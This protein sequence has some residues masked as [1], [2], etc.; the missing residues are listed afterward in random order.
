[1]SVYTPL[2]LEE[3]Q[4]FAE[5]YGLAVIDLIPI[6]GGIQNTNYFLVD[7][8]QKQ[9]V[10]TVFEELD[11]EGAGELV[12]VL[13]CLG[14]ADVPVA[15]PLKHHGQAIHTIADKPAQIA[16]RLMGEHPEEATL[17]QIQ[18][19]AQAQAKM[20]LALKDFPLERDF[21]RNHQYWSDVA[22]QL[23][24]NMNED[25]QSLLD[26][27]FQQFAHITQQHPNRPTGFIHSD[28]FR[29]NT[30]FEG[31]QLQGILDFYE[32]NQ[33]EFLFDIAISINDFCTAYPQAHLDQ[34]K[35]DAFL[36]AYQNIRQLTDD[37]LAC[38]NIFLA[39]A[40][41]RFWSMRLQV[42]QKNAEQGRNG[43]DISQKDPLEMRMMLQDRLQRITA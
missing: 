5:P 34:A 37:E 19:I 21:N 13:D 43:E 12:P 18:A 11:A 4:A 25:D 6:Q 15:V 33:D 30:L 29:D 1:M 35:A 26:Q 23:R 22:E 38:L 20:H 3:V 28:L 36:T 9:Y 40:T 7:Q 27:V 41:C 14:D 31:D 32:L 16:P 2:S 24:P 17:V 39:M 10:L 8:S 42:A